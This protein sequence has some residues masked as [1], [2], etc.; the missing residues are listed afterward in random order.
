MSVPPLISSPF[1]IELFHS[2]VC[3]DNSGE[4]QVR[5][6]TR[7][8]EQQGE[9]RRSLSHTKKGDFQRLYTETAKLKTPNLITFRMRCNR[10]SFSAQS[11]RQTSD[12]GKNDSGLEVYLFFWISET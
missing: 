10:F 11:G 9:A 1:F 3:H 2:K 5:L 4:K 6:K 8:L 7:E 12:S